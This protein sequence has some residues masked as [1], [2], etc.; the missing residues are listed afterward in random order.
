MVRFLTVNANLSLPQSETNETAHSIF[1]LSLPKK[2]VEPTVP[3]PPSTHIQKIFVL[4][5][6]ILMYN[7]KYVIFRVLRI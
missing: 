7:Y 2:P 3:P 4:I 5:P 1:H 6:T